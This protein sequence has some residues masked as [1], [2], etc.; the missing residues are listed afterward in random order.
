[1]CHCYLYILYT[2]P[3]L[4]KYPD[5]QILNQTQFGLIEQ[6]TLYNGRWNTHQLNQNNYNE[7]GT[8]KFFIENWMFRTH[9]ITKVPRWLPHHELPKRIQR[10]QFQISQSDIHN[11]SFSF[12]QTT[13][14]LAIAQ[15]AIN[16]IVVRKQ[17]ENLNITYTSSLISFVPKISSGFLGRNEVKEFCRRWISQTN[18]IVK[19]DDL[20]Y[21]PCTLESAKMDPELVVDFTC[22]SIEPDCHENINAHRCFLKWINN[23]YV[24]GCFC[25]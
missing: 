4:H 19:A 15:F 21:C 14:P 11:G 10:L 18:E 12:T 5:I 17:T 24:H 13:L 23:T 1:M 2:V 8:I 9:P 6:D 7:S 3:P 22:S 25:K 20:T 16:I